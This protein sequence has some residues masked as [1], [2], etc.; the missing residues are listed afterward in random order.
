[1]LPRRRMDPETRRRMREV[2]V[3]SA[4]PIM[5]GVGPA[6]GWYVGHLARERWDGPVWWEAAGAFIG[7][8]AAVRQIYK[9]IK[10]GG[11]GG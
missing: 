3:F 9:A 6:L 5:L 11:D 10:Q 4:L 2:G 8:L 7:L 1:M